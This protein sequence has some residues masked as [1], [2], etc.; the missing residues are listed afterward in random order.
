VK[1][2]GSKRVMLK[3]G[4]GDLL[5]LEVPKSSRF[6]DL[7]A[8]SGAVSGHVAQKFP[9]PVLACDLQE[10]SIVLARSLIS[11]KGN[12][13]IAKEWKHWLA[14]ARMKFPARTP[15]SAFPMTKAR[16]KAT[17]D[18]CA[19]QKLPI[20]Q[21][22][23]GH[24]YSAQQALWLDAL[25]LT[26]PTKKPIA[27][28]AL[29]ALIQAASQCAAAPGHTA[30]PFQPTRTAKQFL[31]EAWKRSILKYVERNFLLNFERPAQKQGIARKMD[32]NQA[33]KGLKSSDLVFIDPP[34]SGVQYSRFYHVLETVA[35]GRCG[36]VTGVG[37]YP[38]SE[39][40][41]QSKYSLKTESE[42]AMRE[43]FRSLAKRKVRAIV[44]FP[45]H[46][47]S[48]GL[49]G[50]Q[51]ASLAESFFR[52][53]ETS[54]KSRFSTLGGTGDDS[55][56][57]VGRAA[58]HKAEELLLMLHPKEGSGKQNAKVT[59]RVVTPRPRRRL[60]AS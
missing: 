56:N 58:R 28:A 1:Y 54:V 22:Y 57:S 40:R 12:H 27:T 7:F 41:P 16:V 60:Y 35:L 55:V 17:R 19:K 14:R 49:S 38:S 39:E 15:P 52:V 42:N 13:D 23:G 51:V 18:W 37:R 8:G 48:N 31:S 32:A 47:C 53:S 33:A 50:K 11:P 45:N 46:E 5:N 36:M 3:N 26:I 9:I 21:A 29:A 34:Y 59:S 4:L 30:Q 6:V 10:Y 44:T 24:Y 20:T 25:R 43:L 2:M